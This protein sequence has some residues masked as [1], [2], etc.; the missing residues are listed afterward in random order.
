MSEVK[1]GVSLSRLTTFKLGGPARFFFSVASTKDL[2]FACDFARDKGLDM[3]ILGGGSNVVF[4]DEGFNGLVIHIDIRGVSYE[5]GDQIVTVAVGAGENFDEFVAD[6]VSKNLYG[7]ENLSGIPGS[8]GGSPVQNINAYGAEIKS[9]ISKVI[10]FDK[11]D[12]SKKTIDNADCK[13]DY[14]DSMFKH[15]GG[16]DLVITQVV[17]KLARE[18]AVNTSYSDVNNY[19]RERK[20]TR[21]TL[22]QMRESI[23]EI[24]SRKFPN[25]S[26]VGTA[27]SFFK[28]P[29]ISEAHY[30]RLR[31]EYGNL[32]GFPVTNGVKIPLA[33]ILDHILNLNG[34]VRGR[35]EAFKYQPQALI[36]IGGASTR[37]LLQFAEQIRDDVYDK[38]KINIVPEV[39]IIKK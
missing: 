33:W 9:T 13:F 27:G 1:E 31:A 24:R 28:N 14:R 34:V 2:A 32:P 6:T 16:A 25:I 3:F 8:V 21:P 36:N 23:L 10:V 22:L 15:D 18:G 11:N 26:K 5:E 39:S 35:V 4:A 20:M 19:F 37:E 17:F 38:T 29:I 12:N 30:E 7:L